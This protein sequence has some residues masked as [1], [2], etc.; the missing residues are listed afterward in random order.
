[1]T[2]I[3][4]IFR[5]HCTTL[6]WEFSYGNKSNLNLLKSDKAADKIYFLLDPVARTG[7][8]SEYG[9]D[10]ET[11][12]NT[13]FLL[14]KKSNFDNVYD[15][16]KGVDKADGKYEKNIKSMFEDEFFKFKKLIECSDYQTVNWKVID[17][18]NALDANTDG[19]LVTYNLKIL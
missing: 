18:V 13:E 4:G 16:Q 12:F 14:V 5:T 11:T 3:V 17:A 8:G 19:V 7:E 9:S 15:N 6:G 2:D 10:G 1:M